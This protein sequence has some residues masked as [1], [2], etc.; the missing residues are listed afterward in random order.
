M[1]QAH[2]C[3]LRS[4]LSFNS[5][6]LGIQILLLYHNTHEKSS[7]QYIGLICDESL[8]CRGL[9]SNPGHFGSSAFILVLCG[10]SRLL[11]SWCAGSRC[12]MVGSDEDHGSSKRPNVEDRGWSSTGW[13]IRRSGDAVCGL[14]RAR[15]DE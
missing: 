14:H 10:E 15:G 7:G 5:L 1:E 9:N 2:S 4:I 8:T 13:T 12:D 6:T 3:A 11:V